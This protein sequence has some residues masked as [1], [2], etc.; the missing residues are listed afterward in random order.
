MENRGKVKDK[1]LKAGS[2]L[3]IISER[4]EQFEHHYSKQELDMSKRFLVT[5]GEGFLGSHLCEAPLERGDEVLC[6]DNF[7]TGIKDNVKH[8]LENYH[9]EL[10]PP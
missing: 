4:F 7:F 5:G 6:L 2:G 8:L 1:R 9:F 3:R 10:Y